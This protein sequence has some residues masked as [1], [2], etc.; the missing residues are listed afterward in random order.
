MCVDMYIFMYIKEKRKQGSIINVIF[1]GL[2]LILKL[3]I[4]S[5]KALKN[6]M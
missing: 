6:N 4:N 5:E 2:A 3:T 1:L